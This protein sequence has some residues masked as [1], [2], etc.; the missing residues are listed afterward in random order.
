MTGNT[1]TLLGT[2]SGLPQAARAASG[3]V[4]KTGASL[5]LFDC[6]GGVT[7]SFM[8]R[9]FTPRQVERVFIS[10]THPDHVC[11]LPLLI[12]LMYLTGNKNRLD[13]YL[14]EEFVE[15]FRAFM[16]ALYLFPEKLPFEINLIGYADGYVYEGEFSLKAIGNCHLKGYDKYI[17]EFGYSNRMQSHSFK[18]SVKD[19]SLLYSGDLGSLADVREHLDGLDYVIIEATHVDFGEFLEFTSNI[20][21]GQYILT[22]LG[23]QREVLELNQRARDNGLHNI[24]TAVD[25]M[26]LTL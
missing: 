8:R 21:V 14:P 6:G 3:Y 26:V 13:L 25:G 19:K 23:S 12:Q 18:I 7:S 4:L 10:H 1:F 2:S 24:I 11:E 15:P 16:P 22:H 17:E 20:R 9:G 5:S